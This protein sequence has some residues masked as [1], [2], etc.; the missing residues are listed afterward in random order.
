MFHHASIKV[1][2]TYLLS[3]NVERFILIELNRICRPCHTFWC[4]T[5]IFEMQ[6]MIKKKKQVLFI[7]GIK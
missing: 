1:F 6:Q 5:F 7:W 4:L 2:Y 3:F